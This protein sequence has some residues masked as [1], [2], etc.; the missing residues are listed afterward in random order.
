MGSEC[1]EDR[2]EGGTTTSRQTCQCLV[3]NKRAFS[4]CKKLR[5]DLGAQGAFPGA[6]KVGSLIQS[7]GRKSPQKRQIESRSKATM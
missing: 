3:G 5:K 1:V 2:W 4:F 6:Q 7:A